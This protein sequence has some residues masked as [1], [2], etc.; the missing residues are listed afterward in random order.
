MP[1]LVAVLVRGDSMS[2]TLDDGWTVYYQDRRDQ[3]DETLHAKLCIVGL[4]DGRVLVKKLYPGR[5]RGHYDLHSTNAPA[6]MDQPV[7]W[8][9]KI[10]WIQPK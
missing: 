9:A 6:L 3:P 2:G 7:D 10:T 4:T 8:A 5:K 1:S